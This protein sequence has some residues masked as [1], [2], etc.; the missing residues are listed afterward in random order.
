MKTFFVRY[1]FLACAILFFSCASSLGPYRPLSDIPNAAVIGTVQTSFESMNSGYQKSLIDEAAYVSLMDAARKEYQGNID[2]REITWTFIGWNSV[3]HINEFSAV[4]KIIL[5]TGTSARVI[6]G[7][8][9]RA[10]GQMLKNVPPKSSIAIVYITAPDKNTT[11]YLAGELEFIL[12]DAGYTIVDRT[13]LGKIREEQSLQMS[14]EVDDAT[15]VSIGKITGAGIIVTG[16][17]DSEGDLRR[18]RLRALDT[19]TA[20]VVGIASE[21]F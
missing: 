2:V 15:A 19:Q 7:A 9:A 21:P 18:L 16:S 3:K 17:V 11:D 5:L 8:L 10:A 13:Q 20:Q 1:G 4:G 14:G 6:E 12:V